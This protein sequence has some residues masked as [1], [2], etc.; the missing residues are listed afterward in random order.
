MILIKFFYR[1]IAYFKNPNR[2]IKIL[3]KNKVEC[4]NP[5]EKFELLSKKNKY[6]NSLKFTGKTVSLPC[7]P[8]L[9]T[10]QLQHI[11]KALKE[12]KSEF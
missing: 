8:S 9:T 4:I 11:G 7:Y 1:S 2:I 12:I 10:G 6:K 5:L 3:K